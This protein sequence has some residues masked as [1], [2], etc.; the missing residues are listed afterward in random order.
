[1]KNVTSSTRTDQHFFGA[2][3]RCAPDICFPLII[4]RRK[5]CHDDFIESFSGM[6]F[7]FFSSNALSAPVPAGSLVF[8]RFSWHVVAPGCCGAFLAG[9]TCPRVSF[10]L[11]LGQANPWESAKWP[12][13]Q[14]H[15]IQDL[16]YLPPHPGVGFQQKSISAG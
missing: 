7:L 4:L 3:V 14:T 12:R 16:D 11:M 5:E 13:I 2:A 6:D 8:P 10:F 15:Q 1:M 9:P